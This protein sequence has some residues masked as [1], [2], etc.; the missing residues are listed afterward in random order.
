MGLPWDLVMLERGWT[1]MHTSDAGGMQMVFYGGTLV[2][3]VSLR[4]SRTSWP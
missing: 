3:S 4:L 1:L 2:G